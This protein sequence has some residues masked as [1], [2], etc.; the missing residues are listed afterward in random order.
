MFLSIEVLKNMHMLLPNLLSYSAQAF[1]EVTYGKT[2]FAALYA[3]LDEMADL[4]AL[5]P[6]KIFSFLGTM[7]ERKRI[8]AR[9]QLIL[10]QMSEAKPPGTKAAAK[11]AAKAAGVAA[12]AAG[13]ASASA[14]AAAAKAAA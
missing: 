13:S 7:D 1:G 10:K 3:K 6:I 14:K 12:K 2:A 9:L 8:K 4:P 11:A 5:E